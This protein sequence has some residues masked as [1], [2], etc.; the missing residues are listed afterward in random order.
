MSGTSLIRSHVLKSVRT[1]YRVY[2]GKNKSVTIFFDKGNK[3]WQPP[4]DSRRFSAGLPQRTSVCN[5]PSA[6]T[7][8]KFKPPDKEVWKICPS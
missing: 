4:F 7:Q 8:Y 2:F 3:N 6:L 5:S 1:A